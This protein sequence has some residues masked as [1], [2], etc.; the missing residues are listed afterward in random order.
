MTKCPYCF[1]DL[2]EKYAFQC[3]GRCNAVEDPVG[4]RLW[5]APRVWKPTVVIS[6]QPGHPPDQVSNPPAC[7]HCDGPMAECCPT[8]HQFL[9]QDW[10]QGSATCIA[11][12]GAR[13]T[14]KSIYIGVLVK[15]LEL[16]AG[17]HR[18]TLGFVDGASR[19]VYQRIYEEQ[20]FVRRGIIA[21]TPRANL[22]DSYQRQPI[23]LS[24]GILNGRRRF[25]VLRDV[26]GEDLENRVDDATHLGFFSHASVVLFLFDPTRVPE[27]RNQLQDLIPA[28]LHSGGDPA[29]VLGNLNLLIGSG[30]PRLGIVLSKF[31]TMQ[32][33]T[34]VADTEL[35][36]IMSNAGAA[37]M[38]DPGVLATG[39]GEEDGIL[40]DAEVRSLLQRLNAGHIVTAIERPHSG[41]VLD[42]RFFVVSALGAPTE[43]EK[44][45]DHGIAS[46][47]CLDPIR[48]AL[49]WDGA[50]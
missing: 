45:H 22:A 43:G 33:L 44:L 28:Q 11:L 25:L 35:S 12:A 38:R 23:I 27:V 20:L 26:A 42:H 10:R 7:R 48:W 50:I 39:Y 46:F 40:L 5:G 36:R 29:V 37:F 30:Q 14:G 24:L 49:R 8:C 2:A 1:H 41:R 31:D 6:P 15:L 17:A 32:T 21:P 47:R 18:T 34:Q 16:F 19:E 13:A 3:Q 9:P 4:T